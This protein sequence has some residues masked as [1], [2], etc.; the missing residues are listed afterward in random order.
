LELQQQVKR[1]LIVSFGR[2]RWQDDGVNSA[3]AL[4]RFKPCRA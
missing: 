2:L 4:C 3:M 1:A